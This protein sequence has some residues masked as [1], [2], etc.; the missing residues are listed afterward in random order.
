MKTTKPLVLLDV[1]GVINDLASLENSARSIGTEIVKAGE[2]TV[3]IPPYMGE[4]IRHLNDVTEIVWCT[5]WRNRANEFISPILGI[6]ND[7]KV[8]TDGTAIRFTSWK[9]NAMR[10]F[11]IPALTDGREVYWIEDFYGS[12]PQV[13]KNGDLGTH[14]IDTA[15][16][17]ETRSRLE[18]NDLPPHLRPRGLKTNHAVKVETTRRQVSWWDDRKA[19]FG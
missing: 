10:E 9:A 14:L 13:P 15:P 4:L 16:P 7:L 11:A 18:V 3:H 19:N 8:A 6:P 2:Y 17:G 12:Y 1:D 5:T